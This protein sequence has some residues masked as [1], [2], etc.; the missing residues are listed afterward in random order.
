MLLLAA[1]QAYGKRARSEQQ[2]AR[3][4]ERHDFLVRGGSVSRAGRS[5]G[6]N[7]SSTTDT[8]EPLS[9]NML[10]ARKH[11]HEKSLPP[12]SQADL[13][14]EPE[15]APST[16]HAM[17]QS[18]QFSIHHEETAFSNDEAGYAAR[19]PGSASDRQEHGEAQPSGA[20]ANMG[21]RGDVKAR[22][23]HY[24]HASR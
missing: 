3:V 10:R 22:S 14:H 9:A 20:R 4:F 17:I 1:I 13:R 5:Y 2:L 12:R 21:N 11:I 24:T 16:E 6:E 18:S 23:A 7:P 15:F 8:T 19:G